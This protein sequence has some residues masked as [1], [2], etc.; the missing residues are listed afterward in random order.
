MLGLI[1]KRLPRMTGHFRSNVWD[2][3]LIIAQIVAM[4]SQ[5]Y[6]LLGIWSYIMNMI[7][8]FDSSLDQVFT[9]TDIDVLEDSGRLNVIAFLLNS[10]TSALALWFIVQ[11][12]KLCLDFSVTAHLLH[13]LGCLIYNS[14]IPSTLP[15][16]IINVI[17]IALM[18]VTG[19]FLC[20]RTEMKAIPLSMG[21]KADL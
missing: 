11:R 15:W 7:G 20:M 13:F 12:T 17:S 14:H 4:Q 6:L 5:F 9:Q 21:P 2:P 16:W 8:K 10:L 18:T 3:V 1:R 19:E